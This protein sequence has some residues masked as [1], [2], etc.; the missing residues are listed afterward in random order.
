M[1][2]KK[3]HKQH[4]L[5]DTEEES[6]ERRLGLTGLGVTGVVSPKELRLL[7]KVLMLL[8]NPRVLGSVPTGKLKG[9]VE[10]DPVVGLKTFTV[11][12]TK[13]GWEEE[14]EEKVEVE[15]VEVRGWT[16][17]G[18]VKL[19]VGGVGR[20]SPKFE[21]GLLFENK[22]EGEEMGDV[23]IDEMEGL[24]L[25]D[26]E[27]VVVVLENV[28]GEGVKDVTEGVVDVGVGVN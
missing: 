28:I 25:V 20:F 27:V 5:G 18:G 12:L 23:V 1:D 11:G 24:E 21:L 10:V 13:E 7:L 4:Q 17:V 22:K 15:E 9:S 3:I 8:V 14:E 26:V 19:N 2:T 16:D 6:W